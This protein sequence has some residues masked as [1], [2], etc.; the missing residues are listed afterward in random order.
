MGFLSSSSLLS[1][2][3]DNIPS[4]SP[5]QQQQV[6]HQ[7]PQSQLQPHLPTPMPLVKLRNIEISGTFSE[8]VAITISHAA[9]AFRDTLESIKANSYSYQANVTKSKITWSVELPKLK[10]IELIG[11]Q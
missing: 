6:Q 9:F 11:R 1:S 5:R 8:N 2:S 10:S 4:P 3:F 7:Q